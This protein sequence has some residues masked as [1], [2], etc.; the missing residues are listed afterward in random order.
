MRNKKIIFQKSKGVASLIT[1]VILSSI[2]FLVVFSSAII[3][4]W[5]MMKFKNNFSSL[6]AYNAAYSG[7]QDA[8]IK[9][10]RNFNFNGSYNLSVNRENDVSVSVL[11]SNNTAT[12][13][14]SSSFLN[15][16]K[17]LQVIASI[18]TE[19]GKITITSLK[20]ISY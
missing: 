2:I 3:S 12:I 17:K 15:Q 10:E 4:F 18:N 8:L 7:I 1:I 9:L 5:Q 6:A 13:T 16:Y 11:N 14:S 19:T 20:E